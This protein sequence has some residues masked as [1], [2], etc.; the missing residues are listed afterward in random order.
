MLT[1]TQNAA[2]AAWYE[3]AQEAEAAKLV[4]AREQAA[5]KTACEALTPLLPDA[6]GEGTVYADLPEGWR[7]KRTIGY[8]RTIDDKIVEALRVPL[9]L[10][11]VSLDTL[12]ERKPSLKLK[13]YREL[14]AEAK[15]IFDACLTTTPGLPT[16]ELV[17]PKAAK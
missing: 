8:T 6:D 4:I 2:L 15:A 17:A 5:R 11:L 7:L 10:M 12:V 14:T 9:S 16:L 13:N 3:A 1:P